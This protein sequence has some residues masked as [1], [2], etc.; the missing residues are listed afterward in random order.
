MKI[1]VS[2]GIEK[3][4]L[5]VPA[6]AGLSESAAIE[7]LTDLGFEVGETEYIVSDKPVGTVISQSAPFGAELS[8]GSRIYL[9]VSIGN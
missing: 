9:T 5:T 2:K 4:M 7:R 3:N 1:W 8:E 6:L